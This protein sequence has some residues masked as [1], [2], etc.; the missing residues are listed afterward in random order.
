MEELMPF[1]LTLT[2]GQ[3]FLF[4]IKLK[5]QMPSYC[6]TSATKVRQ[7]GK[8]KI[9]LSVFGEGRKPKEGYDRLGE[10]TLL[11]VHTLLFGE[12]ST[13]QQRKPMGLRRVMKF[14]FQT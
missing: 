13:S 14:N 12:C 11:T 5:F 2:S 3:T 4:L 10:S 6:A 8:R 1:F 7:E 9:S